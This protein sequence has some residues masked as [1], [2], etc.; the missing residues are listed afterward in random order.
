[1]EWFTRFGN[2]L[3]FMPDTPALAFD[4]ATAGP[5]HDM[6][7]YTLAYNSQ[8]SPTPLETY[9]TNDAPLAPDQEV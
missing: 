2:M 4:F 8:A 6:F 5:A 7:A 9:P 1:M 3:Q